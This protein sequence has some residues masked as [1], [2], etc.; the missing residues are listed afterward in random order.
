MKHYFTFNKQ[1]ATSTEVILKMG[2]YEFRAV[3]ENK[4][5]PDLVNTIIFDE[6]EYEDKV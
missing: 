5:M 3:V 2:D 1:T 6:S 4:Q